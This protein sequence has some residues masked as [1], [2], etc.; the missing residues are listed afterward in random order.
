MA[1]GTSGTV[2]PASNFV[3]SAEYAGART[4]LIN[5]EA[6]DPRNP[7]FKEEILGPAEEIVPRLV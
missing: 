4:I 6:M 2:S 1:I 3:R 5:L 7:A